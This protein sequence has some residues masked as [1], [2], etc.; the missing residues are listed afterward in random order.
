M[1]SELRLAAMNLRSEEKEVETN[2]VKKADK[3]VVSFVVQNNVIDIPG[4]EL[5]IAIREP[6]GRIMIGEGWNAG[7]FDTKDGRKEYTRKVRFEYTRGE[8]KRLIFSVQT[9]TFQKGTYKMNVY[10]NGV[11]IGVAS[12]MLS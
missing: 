6:S 2:S 12:W 7:T 10:H 3:F 5:V 11:V 1:A 9:E 8:Q 4:A